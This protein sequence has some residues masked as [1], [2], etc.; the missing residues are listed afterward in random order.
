MTEYSGFW[1]NAN[2]GDVDTNGLFASPYY[3]VSRALFHSLEMASGAARAYVLG[4]V[5]NSLEVKQSGTPGMSVIVRSGKMFVQ[6]YF[7]YND[8]DKTLAV[9]AA[10][11]TNPRIDL[12]V[13]RVTPASGTQAVRIVVLTGTAA[14]TPSRPA[15]TQ[16]AT[17]Y[18]VAIAELWIPA[19][20]TTVTDPYIHDL[21]DYAPNWDAA[22][23]QN[24]FPENML[25]NSELMG[26]ISN[27]GFN[28]YQA[29]G[30][31][32]TDYGASGRVGAITPPTQ[33]RRG[34]ML[35]TAAV[36][37]VDKAWLTDYI[38]VVG[39]ATYTIK[40]LIQCYTGNTSGSEV[41]LGSDG[42]S[43]LLIIKSYFR[44]GVWEECQITFT[45]PND[46][47][48]IAFG[49]RSL[50][51]NKIT[52]SGASMM[53]RGYYTG[54]WRTVSGEIIMCSPVT[55]ATYTATAKSTSTATIA[56]G[57]TGSVFGTSIPSGIRAIIV[58]VEINDSGSAAGVAS[59]K[60]GPTTTETDLAIILDGVVN[61]KIRAA[62]GII[63]IPYPY[64]F[65][66]S[67]IAL[68]PT[69]GVN[70]VATG[71]GTLDVTIK[72]IGVITA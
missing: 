59:I 18:E 6:G 49:W 1:D 22:N 52:I 30:T 53:V 16:N 7:Y 35:S 63:R 68:G 55:A 26:A 45:V 23:Q 21:R 5:N 28:G 43:P 71:V 20:S 12:V 31:P 42:A 32:G 14:A 64:D 15:L 36:N 2:G 46:A 17:T 65:T 3:S 33:Q 11:A 62:Q 66:A 41:I 47:T 8:A 9:S 51:I 37:G 60:I 44:I 10:H 61:D 27:N 67:I 4:G 40:T 57:P 50:A 72:I 38:P 25:Q 29:A 58:Y 48:Y 34:N 69:F 24:G 19:T 56:L 54:P 13:V 39:G 70:M